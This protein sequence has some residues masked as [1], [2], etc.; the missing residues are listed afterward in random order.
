MAQKNKNTHILYSDN[1]RGTV[2]I[3][4]EV[5]STIAAVAATEVEGVASI[6]GGITFEKAARAGGRAL[7]KGVRT[8]IADDSISVR[9]IIIVKYDYS[10]PDTTAKVQER[11]KSALETMTGFCVKEVNVSVA[12]VQVDQTAE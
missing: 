12:D 9:L 5:I 6:A 11:V 7:A 3:G 8:E 4:D 2:L 1:A 10:I